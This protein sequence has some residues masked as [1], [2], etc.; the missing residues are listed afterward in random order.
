MLEIWDL[1]DENGNKT[2]KIFE[3][4]TPFPEGYYHLGVD[5]WMVN[6]KNEI[7][8]QK[9]SPNKRNSPNVWAMKIGRAHV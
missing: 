9:R 5:V 1:L 3:R 4:G 6:A 8:I 2:G 7:L